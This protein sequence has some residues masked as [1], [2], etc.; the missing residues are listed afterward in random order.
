MIIERELRLYTHSRQPADQQRGMQD[1]GAGQY[2]NAGVGAR[3]LG[4]LGGL[5]RPR[6]SADRHRQK[7][8]ADCPHPGSAGTCAAAYSAPGRAGASPSPPSRLSQ[9]SPALRP[10][11]AEA[12]RHSSVPSPGRSGDRRAQRVRGPQDPNCRGGAGGGRRK[13]RKTWRRRGGRQK[14]ERPKTRRKW[15]RG[16]RGGASAEQGADA[17]RAQ[18]LPKASPA[19]PPGRAAPPTPRPAQAGAWRRREVAEFLELTAE[20]EG[21]RPRWA[22][23]GAQARPRDRVRICGPP[24]GAGLLRLRH[25]PPL[26][27]WTP[28]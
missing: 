27:A 1:R 5:E 25:T 8:R 17:E 12:S 9:P 7:S 3:C 20:P 16:S 14:K 26:W 22:R 23:S 10:P 4:C 15:A 18:R 28:Q 19:A 24:T 6:E 13:K 11:P 21:S 2:R